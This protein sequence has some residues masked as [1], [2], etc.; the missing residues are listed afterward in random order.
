M[1]LIKQFLPIQKG[2][3]SC[4]HELDH[5]NGVVLWDIHHHEY[6]CDLQLL[7][8][9]LILV[10]KELNSA[11][12]SELLWKATFCLECCLRCIDLVLKYFYLF[13]FLFRSGC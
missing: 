12:K 3:I 5:F 2:G 1:Y 11:T 8:A 10:K 4:G 6:Q 13:V 9:S 7:P